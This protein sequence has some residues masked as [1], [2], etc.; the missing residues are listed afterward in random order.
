MPKTFP[1]AQ[2]FESGARPPIV[3]TPVESNLIEAVGYDTTSATLAV[4]FKR[5]DGA[6]GPIYHYPD[7]S[8][9]MHAEFIGAESI[10]KYHGAHIKPL[11]FK[12]YHP[13]P[14]A[15]AQTAEHADA[16]A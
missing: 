2:S 9:V 8:P 3:L 12:K 1:A 14:A 11:P 16:S 5:K 13:E 10:G 15:D 4:T 7:V 6:P